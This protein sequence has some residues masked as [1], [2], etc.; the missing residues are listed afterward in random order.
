VLRR[1][2]QARFGQGEG[3]VGE[4]AQPRRQQD[5][6]AQGAGRVAVVIQ[7]QRGSLGGKSP[8]DRRGNGRPVR[9]G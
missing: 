6:Q 4:G 9:G 1:D 8:A 3:G 5:D 7:A 2:G